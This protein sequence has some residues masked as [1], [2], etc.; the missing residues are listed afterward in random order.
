MIRLSTTGADF[1]AQF[2]ALLAQARDT[3]QTVDA[4]VAAIIAEL[5][6]R[7]DAALLEYTARFDRMTLTADRIRIASEE[8]D[9]SYDGTEMTVAFNPDY[10]AAGVDAVDAEEVTLSTLDP[11]KP[12]APVTI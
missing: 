2:A 8:I 3:T 1:A 10:L 6:A 5:R 9:A 7:G 4:A 11:M 12:A